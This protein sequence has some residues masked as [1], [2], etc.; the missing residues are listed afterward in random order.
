MTTASNPHSTQGNVEPRKVAVVCP[1]SYFNCSL[2]AC[3]DCA[4][5]PVACSP[6]HTANR[7]PFAP[8]VIEGAPATERA[9]PLE[10]ISRAL[11]VLACLGALAAVGGFAMGYFSLPEWRL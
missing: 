9:S 7:Y 3:R 10:A 5:C 4:E 6:P 11:L 2:G 1:T 8:D